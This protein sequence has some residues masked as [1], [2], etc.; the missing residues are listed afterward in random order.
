MIYFLTMYADSDRCSFRGPFSPDFSGASLSTVFDDGKLVIRRTTEP[1]GLRFIGDLDVSNVD[2]VSRALAKA[3][4]RPGEVTI[5]LGGLHFCDVSGMRALVKAAG[6]RARPRLVFAEVPAPL[7]RVMALA[8]LPGLPEPADAT[9]KVD[10]RSLLGGS[11]PAG[12][13]AK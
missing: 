11:A 12:R 1:E 10:P 7:A 8:G 5:D 3:A 2:A 4:K 6:G 13:V 9:E